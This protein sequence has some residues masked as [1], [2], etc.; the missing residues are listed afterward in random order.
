MAPASGVNSS[1]PPYAH[2]AAQLTS[3]AQ[4]AQTVHAQPVQPEES[5]SQPAMP[6]PVESEQPTDNN[7]QKP[8]MAGRSQLVFNERGQL[9]IDSSRSSHSQNRVDESATKA[10]SVRSSHSQNKVDNSSE[11]QSE[12][13]KEQSEETKEQSEE[14]KEQSEE[15][16]LESIVNRIQQSEHFGHQFK[17]TEPRSLIMIKDGK[18]SHFKSLGEFHQK[19]GSRIAG[20]KLPTVGSQ[21]P[22]KG[23]VLI[24]VK[25]GN[26]LSLS[27]K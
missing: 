25:S 22:W 4:A 8:I 1:I 3:F 9:S 23:S 16:E 27:L 11:K 12:E 2:P 7:K 18:V 19:Q 24:A 10:M 15:T 17:K 26:N 6:E 13:L 14:T 21:I 5:K 20:S